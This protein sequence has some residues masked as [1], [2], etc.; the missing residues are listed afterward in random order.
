MNGSRNAVTRDKFPLTAQ[1]SYWVFLRTDIDGF[2]LKLMS[3]NV[4]SPDFFEELRDWSSWKHLILQKYLRVWVSMLGSRHKELAFVDAFAGAGQYEGDIDGSPLL[5]AKWNDHPLLAGKG[6]MVVYAC[7]V[8]RDSF[9]QLEQ[10]LTPWSNRQPPAARVYNATFERVML[11][12]ME[13]TRRIP[14]FFFI[15]P[16]GTKDI[17]FPK[18]SPLLEQA[19]RVAT[20]ILI[21]IDPNMLSRIVGQ[22]LNPDT[23]PQTSAR[24]RS[25]ALALNLNVGAIEANGDQPGMVE[26][27]R[28]YAEPFRERYRYVQLIPIRASYF[29][30]VKYYLLHATN[31]PDGCSKINDILSTTEDVLFEKTLLD[32]AGD[33]GFL[34][35]P[36]RMPR[37][38]VRHAK[39]RVVAFLTRKGLSSFV[40]VCAD[41]ACELGPDLREKH[42]K[43]A[44]KELVEEGKVLRGDSGELK[45]LTTLRVPT[46]LER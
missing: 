21:R 11:D 8:D 37:L 34:I 25:L 39:S 2:Y 5:A 42:H 3:P 22:I 7:E 31:S 19:D 40:E 6:I 46:L 33:Q 16:C 30:A 9:H 41:L 1:T 44:V 32:D 14:T 27:L 23:N 29:A 35:Q 38:T 43:Q 4:S 10:N 18:L 45:R 20:E 12:I 24:F 15:D 26:L 17:T 36:E 28:Q 13:I